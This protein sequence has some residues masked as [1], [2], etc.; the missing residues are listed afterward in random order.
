MRVYRHQPRSTDIANPRPISFTYSR[1]RRFVRRVVFIAP[2]S[3]SSLSLS[4]PVENR[5]RHF[6]NGNCAREV[7]SLSF[8][9][10]QNETL[11]IC[12]LD[13]PA[14]RLSASLSPRRCRRV[15]LFVSS[16]CTLNTLY[17]SFIHASIYFHCSGHKVMSK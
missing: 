9:L 4:L 2:F 3:S 15:P 12:S 1:N 17:P 8:D 5:P 6:D 10:V 13:K 14:P 16:R 11:E 7:A